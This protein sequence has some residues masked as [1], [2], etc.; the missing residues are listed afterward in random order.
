MRVEPLQARSFHDLQN[1]VASH[2]SPRAQEIRL[3]LSQAS[4]LDREQKDTLYE[5]TLQLFHHMCHSIHEA[6]EWMEAHPDLCP[7]GDSHT[8]V[9]LTGELARCRSVADDIVALNPKALF[10]RNRSPLDPQRKL[11]PLGYTNENGNDCFMNALKQLF[12][13][14]P[15]LY[16][17]IIKKLPPEKFAHLRADATS[18][19]LAQIRKDSTPMGGSRITREE[20]NMQTGR[21]EDVSEVL[22]LFLNEVTDNQFLD[23][24]QP[25]SPQNVVSTNP[26][27]FWIQNTRRFQVDNYD[28]LAL[29]SQQ[30]LQPSGWL[31]PSYEPK[32]FLTLPLKGATDISIEM[33]LK[34]WANSSIATEDG[35]Q[36]HLAEGGSK[37]CPFQE[38]ENRFYD[39]PHHLLCC[40][41]RFEQVDGHSVKENRIVDMPERFVISG[42]IV[43]SR[44]S[45]EYEINGFCCHL[46]P[47]ANGGHYITFLKKNGRWFKCNDQR[48]APAKMSEV[49]EALQKNCYLFFANLKREISLEEARAQWQIRHLQASAL[50]LQL[51]TQDSKKLA[52]SDSPKERIA[53]ERRR[54]DGVAIFGDAIR[55]PEAGND[56]LQSLFENLPEDFQTL[57]LNV[58]Q[59]EKNYHSEAETREH[60]SDLKDIMTHY[61]I[62]EQETDIVR[63]IIDQYLYMKQQY[64]LLM[65]IQDNLLKR[66]EFQLKQLLALQEVL[67]LRNVKKA[68][69]QMIM[70]HLISEIQE[71][72]SP[73][74]E[75]FQVKPLRQKVSALLETTQKDLL[76]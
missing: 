64:L 48:V 28:E 3:K 34:L 20:I 13:N 57:C 33:A 21:Q 7:K 8:F 43:H 74:M 19:H 50:E 55:I 65:Q 2:V 40:L 38:E 54:L 12:M 45:G 6:E 36:V 58:L 11:T 76:S 61:L 70:P 53:A 47:G 37:L 68:H 17:H 24:T 60:L 25:L 29:V 63:N 32:G 75:P 67:Q 49:R 14:L 31:R 5:E 71:E 10:L 46:G 62:K 44:R 27:S 56:V 18:Y 35:F 23:P 26:L 30:S 15:V 51:A 22:A 1:H 9:E 72:L 69:L 39:L 52:L 41:N 66:S 73:L 4:Q 59:L 42:D 16:E